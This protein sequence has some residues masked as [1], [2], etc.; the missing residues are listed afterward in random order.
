MNAAMAYDVLIGHNLGPC[1]TL[2]GIVRAS[3]HGLSASFP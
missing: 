2:P 3:P 1:L